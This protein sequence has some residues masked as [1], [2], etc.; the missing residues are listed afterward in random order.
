MA[1]AKWMGGD[2]FSRFQR[3]MRIS[4]PAPSSKIFDT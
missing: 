4:T 1:P 3:Q 2:H